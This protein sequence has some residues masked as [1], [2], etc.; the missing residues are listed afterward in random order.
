MEG[1]AVKMGERVYFFQTLQ[2]KRDQ[3]RL[4]HPNCSKDH[5]HWLADKLTWE[6]VFVKQPFPGKEPRGAGVHSRGCQNRQTH[7]SQMP[8]APYNGGVNV[9]RIVAINT[10]LIPKA[11]TEETMLGLTNTAMERVEAALKCYINW[12]E[13]C[14]LVIQNGNA[15]VLYVPEVSD[16][17]E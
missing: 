5:F 17:S 13:R 12:G 4:S 11:V 3:V 8:I 14:A 7:S 1:K 16:G 9:P 2:R 10:S 15:Q 6:A